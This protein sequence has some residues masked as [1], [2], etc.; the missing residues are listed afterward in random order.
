M[1]EGSATV[2]K[3]ALH[4]YKLDGENKIKVGICGIHS[5]DNLIPFSRLRSRESKRFLL[6]FGVY[7][8][9]FSCSSVYQYIFLAAVV[10]LP[11]ETWPVAD[12]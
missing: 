7:P 5:S 12:I 6:L 2:A 10:C 8:F 9:P 11:A 3:D 4:N 1:D